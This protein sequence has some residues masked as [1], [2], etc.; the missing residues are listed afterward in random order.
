MLL[1]LKNGEKLI[2]LFIDS[3]YDNW[4]DGFCDLIFNFTKNSGLDENRKIILID[5]GEVTFDKHKVLRKINSIN[6]IKSYSYINLPNRDIKKNYI[7]QMSLR[8]TEK[9]LKLYWN[10]I[11]HSRNLK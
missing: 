1:D 9:N 4:K 10:S 8:V 3:I 6:W 5:F 2:D 11:A 7:K